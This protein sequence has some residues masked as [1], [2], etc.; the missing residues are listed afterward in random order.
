MSTGISTRTGSDFDAIGI[1][2]QYRWGRELKKVKK[3][4]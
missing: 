3:G 1:V 2:W 4:V